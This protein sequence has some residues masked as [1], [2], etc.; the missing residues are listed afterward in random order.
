[1]DITPA[2]KQLI[3]QVQQ[4]KSQYTDAASVLFIDFYCQC[5][6]GMDYLF[7]A[8]V[9]ETI[10]LVDILQWFLD[11]VELGQP[12]TLVSLM[13]KDVVGPTLGEY[14]GDE[15][16]ERQLT[17]AFQGDMKSKLT[18][19]DRMQLKDGQVWLILRELLNAI[20]QIE[21]AQLQAPI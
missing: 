4:L 12:T 18:N 5:K 19:W 6:E 21:Q 9:K 1:M 17:S 11:C 10:R 8:P 2:T 20:A 15:K 7:P 14:L 3:Q 13:W 16:T